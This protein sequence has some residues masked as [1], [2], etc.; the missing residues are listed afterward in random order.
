MKIMTENNDLW[1]IFCFRLLWQYESNCERT[2]ELTETDMRR[3][4]LKSLGFK[5]NSIIASLNY[6]DDLSF[7]PHKVAAENNITANEAFPGLFE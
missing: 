4:V 3:N 6:L 5:E 2:T 7:D 1:P